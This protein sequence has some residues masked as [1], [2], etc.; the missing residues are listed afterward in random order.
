MILIMKGRS[1]LMK[2]SLIILACVFSAAFLIL[3]VW[4]FSAV[5]AYNAAHYPENTTING[6]SC[7][8][9]TVQEA[10]AKLSKVWN[11]KTLVLK[12]GEG[13]TI[14]RIKNLDLSY[15][16]EDGL[17]KVMQQSILSPSIKRAIKKGDDLT[18]PMTAKGTKNFEKQIRRM[19]FLKRSYTTKTKNA[20]VDMSNTDFNIVKEVY[21]DNIS[22]DRFEKKMLDRI[23]AGNWNVTYK[24]SDYYELPTV[25]STSSSLKKKQDYCNKYLTQKIKYN[26][27][28]TSVTITPAQLSKIV[29]ADD[30]GDV[31]ISKKAIK[32]LVHHL[33]YKYDT[34]YATRTFK[35]VSGKKI[36]VYGQG[37]GYLLDQDTEQKALYRIIK[38]GK[39]TERDPKYKQEPLFKGKNELK[40]NFIEINLSTQTLYMVK[41]GK[42]ILSTSVVTGNVSKNH[43]TPEGVF[44]LQGKAT[45]VTLKGYNYDGTTYNSPVSYWMPFDGGIGMHDAPWRSSF[46]GS[47]YYSNGS[48]G[49][50]N[51]PSDGAAFVY[52]HI[53]V[54]WPVVVHW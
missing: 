36:T 20:Y 21:G 13:E 54:G 39:D 30:N 46:G 28:G 12:N 3:G 31:T 23:A 42:T 27:H 9:L 25:L 14:G 11:K 48:H 44:Y 33:A 24:A 16:I 17:T 18:V 37:Y 49:C 6:V 41:N 29:K 45:N 51:M 7:S 26:M 4:R 8:D 40:N 10:S 32:K 5:Y 35:S 19:K 50:V 22:Y 2:K 1:F 52:N 43:G 47:I 53:K 15:D 34:A 38:S